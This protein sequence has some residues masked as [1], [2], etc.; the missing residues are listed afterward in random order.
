MNYENCARCADECG[1]ETER[2]CEHRNVNQKP[3][4][5]HPVPGEVA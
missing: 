5:R 1:A 2:L 3:H 4:H